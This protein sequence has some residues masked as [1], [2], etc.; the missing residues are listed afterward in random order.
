MP[1]TKGVPKIIREG[2]GK[3]IQSKF[4]EGMLFLDT[5]ND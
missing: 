5:N 1:D 2:E 4:S 3:K